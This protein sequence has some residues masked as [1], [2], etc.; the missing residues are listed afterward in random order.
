M[1][2]SA[3]RIVGR[4]TV[5]GGEKGT[6]RQSCAF[7]GIAVLPSGRWIAAWRAAPAKAPC[8]GQHVLLSR[9]DDDGASW[10]PPRRPFVPPSIDGRPGLFRGAHLTALGGRRVMAALCWVDN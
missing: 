8:E 6:D 1:D 5:F 9:S 10:G 7:P 3:L 4:G 2:E